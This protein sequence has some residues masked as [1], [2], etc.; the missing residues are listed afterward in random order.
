M[1]DPTANVGLVMDMRE[2]KR[3]MIHGRPGGHEPEI[4]WDCLEVPPVEWLLTACKGAG[5]GI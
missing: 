4:F 5:G 1:L 3:G 2:G